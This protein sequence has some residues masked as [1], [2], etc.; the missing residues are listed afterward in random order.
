MP[1][2]IM[3]GYHGGGGGD[4]WQNFPGNQV[5][6]L[7]GPPFWPSGSVDRTGPPDSRGLWANQMN[8]RYN[9]PA[10]VGIDMDW[11][12]F[13][14]TTLEL[15]ASVN[16]TALENLTGEYRMTMILLED[17]LIY[18]QTG[19]GSCP[20]SPNYVH[21]HVVRAMVNG[22]TGEEL[23]G[24]NPWNSGEIINKNIFYTVPAEV[25]PDSCRLVILVHKVESALYNSEIQ[26]A[27]EYPLIAPDYVAQIHATSPDIVADN[28]TLAEF[29]TVLRN[30]GFQGDMY[31]IDPE[32]DGPAGWTGEYTTPNG[33]F[34]F[35][36]VD[37]IE[38]ASGD[39]IPITLS[40]NPNGFDGFGTTNAY[41]TSKNN[42]GLSG[43][44]Y[45]RNV[46][47]TGVDILVVD[48][49]TEGYGSLISN[50]LDDVYTGNYGVV[51]REALH[52]AGVDLSN[53]HMLTWSA[54]A[55]LP[56]FYQEEVNA[57]QSYLDVSGNLFINGQDIGRDIFEPGGQSQFAQAFYNNYLHASYEDD[58]GGSYFFTGYA[59]DPISDGLNI[60]LGNVYN[61][62]P[63]EISPFDADATPIF[64][65]GSGPKISSIKVSTT[66]NR[67]VY[68]GVGFEQINNEETRDSILARSVRW[69]TE[70]V[71]VRV[72]EGDGN[73]PD[74]FSLI[75]NYP[76][77]FNPATRIT[78]TVPK[79]SPVTIKVYDL[80]GQEVAVL[81]DEIKKAGTYEV[82]FN[83]LNLSSGVYIYEM[84]SG[85]F[86]SAKKM[87][88]LK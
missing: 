52:P 15:N 11:W 66:T 38:V 31:Y 61:N 59:G 76:N 67:I 64:K 83:A 57:L 75:Q 23:N 16:I 17:G 28:T 68:L 6:S 47:T 9:V 54:G 44:A 8:Q 41:F 12:G 3:I 87:N 74:A 79:E 22:A 78:Y 25:I 50:T 14:P 55:N 77:P 88:I 81:V 21:R 65:F 19:N 2:A 35:G 20:G 48:A 62:S 7:M 53:F 40:I 43:S 45:M 10:T 85:A 36:Q 60:I 1:N 33:T 84:R 18:N 37:S 73:I 30:I 29:S 39:S 49:S 72:S 5:V 13:N 70:N 26:Q 42:P 82:T 58:F 86:G 69:L 71:T 24:V 46:T 51:S 80:I 63:D 34:P 4:P 27:E 32:L 56:V